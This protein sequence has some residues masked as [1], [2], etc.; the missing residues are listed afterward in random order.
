[1]T[2]PFLTHSRQ[3]KLLASVRSPEEAIVAV[4]GGADIVDAKEPAR[5]ALGEVATETLAGIRHV[6]PRSIAV[7]ATTGDIAVTEAERI[8]D[9]CRRVADAGADWV[10]I[11]FFGTSGA[12][13]LLDHL[14]VL[15]TA[16]GR[17]IAVLMADQD[18]DFGIV[19][20]LAGAGFAGVMLDTVAK[21]GQSLTDHISEEVLGEFI[22][23][24]RANHLL[25]GLAGSL[26][27]RHIQQLM[28]LAPDVLGFRGAL[29]RQGQRTDGIEAGL[30]ADVRSAMTDA[31][32]LA[33]MAVRSG[34]ED[35]RQGTTARISGVEKG[36]R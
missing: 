15:E 16:H 26:R 3:V 28:P 14:S 24:A 10:K 13:S 5:G 25:T 18:P 33:V 7:S 34:I 32:A 8:A 35:Q 27:L 21:G 22:A 6:V 31:A 2:R 11:G 30:V 9:A 17:R 20:D 4:R 19:D 1:M 23:R 29:C 36:P 12:A